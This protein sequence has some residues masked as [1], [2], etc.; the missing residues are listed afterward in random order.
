MELRTIE[1]LDLQN[2]EAKRY[3]DILVE[4]INDK[5]NAVAV[6]IGS[7]LSV[8]AGYPSLQDMLREMGTEAGLEYLQNKEISSDWM[9]DFQAIKNALGIERYNARLIEYFDYRTKNQQFNPILLNLLNIPFCAY[10]TTN[11][12]PC[13][14]F[15]S[16]QTPTAARPTIY[17]FPDELPL[18]ELKH[19]QIFHIHGYVEPDNQESVGSIILA[20]EEY[21]YAY[22]TNDF[23][24]YFLHGVFSE[25]DV[26][27]IG[28]GWN[29]LELIETITRAKKTRE[30]REDFAAQRDLR[31][32]RA[33]DIFAI[34]ES[35]AFEKDRDSKNYL[36]ANGILPIVYEKLS[37]SHY[38]LV[39]LV[40]EIQNKT[41]D[42]PIGPMPSLPVGLTGFGDNDE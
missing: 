35:E 11:Y 42:I 24:S 26:L 37:G 38:R 27:F 36:G 25:V 8:D 6:F 20:R 14:E 28:F 18:S 5:D 16:R 31:L 4:R 41:S 39:Q 22:K 21:E 15:A 3:V 17:S 7:G 32:V 33:R 30:V 2:E 34:I 9:D 12:D 13:L 29:D 40:H 23:V 1:E 19:E 10:I